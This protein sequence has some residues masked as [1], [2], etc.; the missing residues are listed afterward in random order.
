[1]SGPP[2]PEVCRGRRYSTRTRHNFL[3]DAVR[4]GPEVVVSDAL[5]M[6]AQ[7]R[8]LLNEQLRDDTNIAPPE[9]CV[10]IIVLFGWICRERNTSGLR[11]IAPTWRASAV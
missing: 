8:G 5:R 11:S 1:M 6:L 7:R 9:T 3:W 10:K 2:V 4:R